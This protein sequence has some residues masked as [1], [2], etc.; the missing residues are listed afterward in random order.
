[1]QIIRNKALLF[2]PIILI[3]AVIATTDF[4]RSSSPKAEPISPAYE[5]SLSYFDD[6]E[7]ENWSLMKEKVNFMKENRVSDANLKEEPE[8]AYQHRFHPDF[9][10]SH[11]RR[12]GRKGDGGKWVCDPHR[13]TQQKS[14]LVYS[15]GSNGDWS[16]EQAVKRNIGS[17]CEIHT[18]DFGD[19]AE[20]SIKAGSNYHQWGISNVNDDK[21]K[22]LEKTVEELGH[23]GRTI[24]I[25][26]IDCEGCEWDTFP[27]WFSSDVILR[28]I[29]VEVH[30]SRTS[31]NSLE[32]KKFYNRLKQEDYSINSLKTKK[33]YNRLKQ[34]DYVIFHR[35]ANIQHSFNQRRP[36]CME[37][38]FLKLNSSFF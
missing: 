12:I 22:T 32:T 21:F 26:K 18:F 24:D 7:P 25:F 16:F 37:V 1:M 30:H 3:L 19:F 38:A 5:E 27:G 17:H 28:Q 36:K 31:I 8:W 15:V 23:I 10:C 4:R 34:E 20:G 35:E 2:F 6:I 11:E 14:C 13:I 29:L 9:L 33:F